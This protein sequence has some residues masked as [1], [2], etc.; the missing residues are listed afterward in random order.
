MSYKATLRQTGDRHRNGP[1]A[2]LFHLHR[3]CAVRYQVVTAKCISGVA[4]LHLHQRIHRTPRKLSEQSTHAEVALQLLIDGVGDWL[5]V[6][7]QALPGHP[8]HVPPVRGRLLH[9]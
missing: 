7:L 8:R 2:I 9:T 3:N 4:R 6:R 1:G 5:H